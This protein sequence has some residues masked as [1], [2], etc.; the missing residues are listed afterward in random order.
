[1]SEIQ[2][3]LGQLPVATIA[4]QAGVEESEARE[5]LQ[6]VLPALVGGMQAN[7][8]DP[9]GAASLQRALGDHAG[10][11]DTRLGG[12]IDPDDGQKIVHNIFGGNSDQIATALG[13]NG[14]LGG[15]IRK[16]LPIVAPIVIAW[17]ANKLFSGGGASTG[18]GAGT[19]QASFPTPQ[20]QAPR[21]GDG[22]LFGNS[23]APERS[24]QPQIQIP[25]GQQR[26]Q[27]PQSGGQPDL[28]DLLG[29]I[30]GGGSSSQQ[31]GG[32]ILGDLL[33]GLLGG[34]RR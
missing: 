6:A 12:D 24:G 27:Q 31:S 19:G 2:E 23:E 5:A 34:G 7:A 11:L 25:T 18:G 21:Q 15:I 13:G 3:L 33:G 30:L 26:Q 4:R 8:Q 22:G 32:G 9:A 17:I 16:I 10:A 29:G 20:Q 1:M 28:G 14:A